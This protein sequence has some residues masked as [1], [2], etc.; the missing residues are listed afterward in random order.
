MFGVD[1]YKREQCRSEH[2]IERQ[3]GTQTI[4][5][6]NRD[7]QSGSEQLDR[8]ITK[9]N[10]FLAATTLSAERNI[11]K[12]RNVVVESDRCATRWATRVWKDDRLFERESMNY[13][14]EKAPDDCADDTGGNVTIHWGYH[15]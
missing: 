3:R 4:V 14:V 8:G 2:K 10:T 7:K 11:T 15:A 9:R 12:H 1:E 5:P 6:R 13:N